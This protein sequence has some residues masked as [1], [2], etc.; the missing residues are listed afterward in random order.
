MKVFSIQ[1]EKIL[2]VLYVIVLFLGVMRSFTRESVAAF[3]MPTSKK[4]IVIDAGHGGWD[5]GKV[6]GDILEKDINLKIALS[7]QSYLEQGGSVV[8][9]TRI[10]D[11][12]LGN[13]KGLDMKT[14]KEISDLSKA[15]LIIS[16]HQ[17]SYPS[18]NVKGAQ[19]F[20]YNDSD[21]SKELAESIQTEIKNFADPQNHREAKSDSSYYILKETKV[22]AVIVEC[23]FLSS[24][25]ER[26]L[27]STEEYQEKIAWSIYRGILNYY[28]D[29]S[30]EIAKH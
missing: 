6:S 25:I 20:Y 27:L 30:S 17:N 12:A 24:D 18:E 4:V 5:P 26:N 2:L 11:E 16:I 13:K 9:M 10:E 21:K 23:G 22:P 19:V 14:R 7:L 1:K 8:M 28:S 29:D 15:D 3:N